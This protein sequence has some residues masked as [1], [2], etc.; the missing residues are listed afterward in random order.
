MTYVIAI[1]VDHEENV[2]ADLTNRLHADF[3]ILATIVRSL[4]CGTE[5]DAS[6]IF[7]AETSFFEGAA[8]LSFVPLE[9]HCPMYAL[10]VV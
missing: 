4:E 6:S 9:K 10:S 8:A 3:T 7:E 1:C 5:E 2:V